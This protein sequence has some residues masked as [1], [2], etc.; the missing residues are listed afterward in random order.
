MNSSTAT[1]ASSKLLFLAFAAV[2]IIWGST[3]F[4]ILVGIE[5]IPPLILAGARHLGAGLILYPVVR[6][7]TGM[8]PHAA[9]WRTAIVSGVLLMLG[10]NGGVCWSEQRVPSGV[11]AL[12]V[13]TVCLWLVIL[14]WLRPGGSRP[15]P[16]VIAGV[17]LGFAG[18]ALLVGPAQLGGA[19][20][21][22]LIGAAVLV[23]ASFS[24]ACGSLY[25]RHGALPASP[26]LGVAMQSLAGGAALWILA[27]FLG[28]WRAFHF[29]AVSLRSGVAL[30]YLIVFGSGLGFTA[31]LYLLKN[32]TP[33]RV[34]TY[35]LAN[36]VVALFL[37]WAL[38]GESV[39]LRTG[40]ASLVILTAVLLVITAP[41]GGRAHAED[42]I[43]A[44]GEA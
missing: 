28:E 25:S 8:Q 35:A 24:W 26:F 14:E 15:G 3:Y 38:A 37:G 12:L 5:T 27:A 16:R 30:V 29:S 40:L 11:A 44:P 13:A 9:Q 41:H 22:D 20:R 7:K 32:S 19:K 42:A 43:P 23:A 21:V 18:L 17:L 31:Y 6:A 36:P 34:G 1:H 10:G 39:T 4:A 2:Y 33:S